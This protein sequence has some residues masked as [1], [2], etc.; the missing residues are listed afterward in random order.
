MKISLD[1]SNI[2]RKN[3][4]L[5]LEGVNGAGKTSVK[6]HIVSELSKRKLPFVETFE[7]GD[8]PLGKTVRELLLGK[9]RNIQS[10]I[11][12]LFLF[13]ADRAEHIERVIG[14]ALK[15]NKLVICD[16]YYYS[17]TAF[18]G[19]GR[20]IDRNLIDDVNRNA[21]GNMLPDLVILLDLDPA[22]GLKRNQQSTSNQGTFSVDAL[23]KEHL[24][25]HIRIRN[26]FLDIAESTPEPFIVLD[27]AR[28]KEAVLQD[29]DRILTHYLS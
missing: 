8:T 26:G 13:A 15:E 28:P 10:P 9:E 11:A 2:K 20:G 23:E 24:D 4:F 17:T 14:K 22:I 6:K 29:I 7:P 1:S 25:F 27:A 18:Q 12:E 16:R 3:G 21:V 19:Y 5:V